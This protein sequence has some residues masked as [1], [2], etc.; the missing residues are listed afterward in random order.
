MIGRIAFGGVAALA[1]MVTAT[2]AFATQGM[3]CSAKGISIDLLY[4][5]AAVPG[6][7]KADLRVGDTLVPTEV[8]RDWADDMVIMV[9]L[10]DPEQTEVMSSL[11]LK[12]S[13]NGWRGT[14]TYM[15]STYKVSC[16]EMG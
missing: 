13:K 4:G 6:L 14:L 16:E 7:L 5:H 15:T 3:A 10:A 8:A 11:R 2:P 9:D 12:P 1:M